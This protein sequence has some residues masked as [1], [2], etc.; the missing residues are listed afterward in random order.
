MG[1]MSNWLFDN[2][3]EGLECAID[4]PAG[5]F[6]CIDYPAEKLL[7][8]A[9]GS[10]VTPAMSMLRWLADTSSKSDIVF[11][12]NVRT[13]EDI[14][15]HQELLH[16]S[17]QRSGKMRLVIVPAATSAGRPWNGAVGKFNET[18][19]RFYAPDFAEREAFV[20]GPSGYTGAVKSLLAS[21]G[22]QMNRHH[23]ESFGGSGGVASTEPGA[24][25]KP[26]APAATPAPRSG[27][28]AVPTGVSAALVPTAPSRQTLDPA[29]APTALKSAAPALITASPSAALYPRT[30]QPAA[31]AASL[32]SAPTT[33]SAP[34]TAANMISATLP[35]ALISAPSAEPRAI[36][37]L[38]AAPTRAAKIHIQSSGQ[39]SG[40]SFVVRAEQTI[41]DAAEA[42]G[43]SLEH[44]CR[45]G[46]CGACKMRKISGSVEMGEGTALSE[47]DIKSGYILTCIGKAVGDVTLSR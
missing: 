44:L 46:I 11:I 20:C 35:A 27:P 21:L 7:F 34:R 47:T 36:P 45:S 5:K 24:G 41:L 17:A 8:V 3:A 40:Q 2:M 9:A 28:G 18:L 22:F 14:I 42:S 29:P 30:M 39:S 43:V 37:A 13:P 10:G 23:D 19:L 31:P 38:T 33:V 4:G 26:A 12:N 25:S 32:S 1:W 16:L 15:F 6:T